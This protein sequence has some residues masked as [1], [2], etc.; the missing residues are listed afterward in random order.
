MSQFLELLR[1]I[2]EMFRLGNDVNRRLIWY[3]DRLSHSAGGPATRTGRRQRRVPGT[4][5]AAGG[6]KRSQREKEEMLRGEQT[7]KITGKKSISA[8]RA[9]RNQNPTTTNTL[10]H[11]LRTVGQGRWGRRA[12]GDAKQRGTKSP[13]TYARDTLQIFHFAPCLAPFSKRGQLPTRNC[14]SHTNAVIHF[15]TWRQR[16][17]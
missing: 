10:G 15:L 12:R 3:V 11:P 5:E 13:K 16:E 17:K 9:R 2:W 7:P 6:P 1:I 4:G 14:R 8:L